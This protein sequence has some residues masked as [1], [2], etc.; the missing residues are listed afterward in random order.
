MKR[1]ASDECSVSTPTSLAT[2]AE[3]DAVQPKP[4]AAGS[5]TSK[6]PLTSPTGRVGAASSAEAA[7]ETSCVA[8]EPTAASRAA[9]MM[10]ADSSDG[11]LRS[12]NPRLSAMMSDAYASLRWLPSSV[13]AAFTPGATNVSDPSAVVSTCASNP[14]YPC[15]KP[16]V[17]PTSWAI[18]LNRS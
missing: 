17:W 6:P 8:P 18:T 13:S 9:A 2:V 1:G 15:R 5:P 11:S 4:G 16:K 12:D 7:I 14:A 10:V 3:P